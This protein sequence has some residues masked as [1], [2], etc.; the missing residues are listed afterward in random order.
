[1]LTLRRRLQ[2][3]SGLPAEERASQAKRWSYL[4]KWRNHNGESQSKIC[5]QPHGV[6][7]HRQ[8]K[9]SAVQLP[10][11]ATLRGG[12]HHTHRGHRQGKERGDR[13]RV[14]AALPEVARARM[15]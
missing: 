6:P 10:V 12:C 8:C 5:T 2:K 13:R 7:G 15:G 11:C 14:A 9:I 4:K 3:S 1:M